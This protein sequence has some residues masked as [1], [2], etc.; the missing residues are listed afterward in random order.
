MVIKAGN[1]GQKIVV[2]VVDS[3]TGIEV[4]VN[5]NDFA[6]E[7]VSGQIIDDFDFLG[8]IGMDVIGVADGGH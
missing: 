1:V 4:E 8:E 5:G 6:R 7:G 2:V 3:Q